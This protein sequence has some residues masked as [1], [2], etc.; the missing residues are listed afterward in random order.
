MWQS[1]P[2]LGTGIVYA[3]L[4]AAAYTFAVALAAGRGRPRLL[5][6]AR[7]GAY[8]TSSLVLFAVLLLSYAFVSHD[9]RIRYV[10]HYSDRRMSTAYLLTSLW[11]GQDGSLLWWSLLLSGYVTACVAWLKGRYRELQPYVIATLMVIVGFFA[12]LMLF[13]A[14]PFETSI[15]G[16]RPDGEGLNP[17]LQN[18]WMI[19]HPPCLYMGF[20]GCSVPFSFCVSALVT[21]RLDNEWVIAVRKWMLFAFLFLSIGNV[22]GMMWAYEELGWG[23]FWAWD[24]VE[25]AACLPW[26][27]AAAYVHSTMIQERRPMLRVWNVFLICLTFFLTIF[28]TFLTRAGI[29]TSVHAFAQSSIGTYFVYFMGVILGAS[30]GLIVWRLPELK[31]KGQIE[32]VASREAMFVANNWALVGGM[33][34]ILVSTM[35]PKISELW[36]ESATVGPPHFN[37]WMGPIGL[38]IFALMGLAPLFGWRKTSGTSIKKAFRAPLIAMAVMIV[39]HAIFGGWLGY[40]PLVAR[41]AFY[42]GVAG[43]VIQKIGSTL[44]A[45][46]I[47]LSA[48]NVAVIV[49]E[50]VRGVNARRTV[51][52][53]R[54][55]AESIPVALFRLVEKN[56]RRYGGYIVHLGIVSMFVGF[57]GTAWNIDRETAMMPGD[58]YRIG[59]Y[60]LTYLGSR[61]CP[62]NP[63]C[64]AEEQSDIEKRML[65]ADIDVARAGKHLGR[66]HPAKFFYQSQPD[67]PT[68]EVSMM[69]SLHEDLYT[70][71][72]QI[73]PQS[74]RATFQFHVNP[75]VSW[76]W[77]GLLV[78]MTGTITSLFPELSFGEVGAWS[79]V[80][81]A[82]GVATGTAFA[83]WIAMAP[84]MGYARDRPVNAAHGAQLAGIADVSLG[85]KLPT[86]RFGMAGFVGLALGSVV[87]IA[88][89]RRDNAKSPPD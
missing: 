82:A 33:T 81:A 79:Y 88:R 50:F 18:Y 74:K 32:A 70:V 67:G 25:N 65:F 36:G 29:I 15:A 80:R 30:A 84:S 11:G 7:L 76:I 40:P 4:I 43:I 54:G 71:V 9:F 28:G 44:P 63:K 60:D 1:L 83:I 75:L 27:T 2:E 45:I 66:V 19:I 86:S 35:Y 72:G 53:K 13:A 3:I 48:F 26:F 17:L 14:N 42:P 59:Q 22:L 37:R 85:R 77:I 51:A 57:T 39:L 20:V 5:Q 16:A 64:S 73:D 23:G 12:M 69:R 52:S 87:S 89:R 78:L 49:Q 34:F 6:A 41:D 24:P 62:G 31:S 47:A 55:E 21:R 56:R 68:T 10:A 8:A 46:I 58:H 61:M 38:V